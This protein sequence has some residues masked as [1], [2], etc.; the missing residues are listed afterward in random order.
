MTMI[1]IIKPI[2]AHG[3]HPAAA[4]I[5]RISDYSL[6]GARW[7]EWPGSYKANR[8]VNMF[9]LNSRSLQA[10]IRHPQMAFKAHTQTLC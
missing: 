8:T 2:Q 3:R 4:K 7:S 1:S 6:D 9:Q 5:H 10:G